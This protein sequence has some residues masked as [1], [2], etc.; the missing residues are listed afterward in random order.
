MLPYILDHLKQ[1]F[2]HRGK[3]LIIE[4]DN[5]NNSLR[6]AILFSLSIYFKFP[7]FETHKLINNQVSIIP[8]NTLLGTLLPTHRSP[9]NDTTLLLPHPAIP[10]SLHLSKTTMH[11]WLINTHTQKRL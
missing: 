4:S 10:P 7:L 9:Q 1:V 5:L 8:S 6:Q 2:L 3:V 11:L